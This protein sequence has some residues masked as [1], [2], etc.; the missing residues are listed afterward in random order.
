[1]SALTE[2]LLRERVSRL[3]D[4]VLAKHGPIEDLEWEVVRCDRCGDTHNLFNG[5]P[6][7][8]TT[9]GNFDEGFI[10]LCRACSG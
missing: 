8:W 4:A 1:M 6:V 5:T 10:D 2:E 3:F 9:S 7:G